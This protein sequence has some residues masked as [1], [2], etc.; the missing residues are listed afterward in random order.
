MA[1]ETGCVV[2]IL[3]AG[4][5]KPLGMPLANELLSEVA[6]FASGDGRSIAGAIKSHLPY[7][8]FSFDKYTGEQGENFGEKI[9]I[10]NPQSLSS[11]KSILERHL[12]KH[13]QEAS[14]HVSALKIVVEGLEQIRDNN[15]LNDETLQH[16]A[17]VAGEQFQSSGGDYIINPKGLQLTPVVR[18][19]FRKVFQNIIQSNEVSADERDTLKE[20]IQSMMNFEELLSDLFTG[21][22]TGDKGDQKKYLYIA[23]LIWAYLRLRMQEGTKGGKLWLYGELEGIPQLDNIITFN[24]TSMFV[25]GPL[26]NRTSYFHGDCLSYLRWDTQELIGD[27]EKI[28]GTAS[29]DAIAEFIKG[30]EIDVE[31]GRTYLP[32][33][34]PPLAIKPILCR[35]FLNTWYRS[36][37]A[38]DRAK[39]I[40]VIGYSFNTVDRH[41]NDL[42]RK[43]A[44]AADAK[45]VVINPDLENTT[46]NV[47]ALLGRSSESLTSVTKAG[48]LVS[49]GGNLV[50]VNARSEELTS[51]NLQ[52]L[53]G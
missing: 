35:E 47:C 48:F 17:V 12:N 5:D 36:G 42:I 10:Q 49:Q 34:V 26:R 2:Y 19:A 4:V 6:V 39:A 14:Q 13:P 11:A 20:L 24:Y 15:Q 22:F 32:G 37:E 31:N 44:G 3:G 16:L 8:H 21:F 45:L 46:A 33:I 9:M 30:L 52:Q 43:R 53:V 25:P 18:Q 51:Q 23:W 1:A 41:F 38:I 28:L 40:V 29:A 27:D 50:L 7:L